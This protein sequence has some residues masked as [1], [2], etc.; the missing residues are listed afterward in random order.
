MRQ[1]NDGKLIA[2]IVQKNNMIKWSILLVLCPFL[3][4]AQHQL[5]ISIEGVESS[6]GTISIGLYNSADGFLKAEKIYKGLLETAK[7]GTTVATFE[8]VPNGTYALAV[9]HDEN[10][11]EEL[12]SNLLGIP[13]EPLGFSKG[14]L[15]TFGPP[16]FEE[17][18]FKVDSDTKI[19]VPI[20]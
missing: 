14:K 7:K 3:A 16:N 5:T 2:T 1:S 20:K 12:D 11:N 4:I 18:A 19:S 17:C 13:K 6:K 15:K 8:D 9:Y 10:S